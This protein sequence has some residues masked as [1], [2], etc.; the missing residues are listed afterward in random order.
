VQPFFLS[1]CGNY[2][3]SILA[4]FPHRTDLDGGVLRRLTLLLN[5]VDWHELGFVCDGRFLFS[6]RSLENTLLPEDFAAYEVG[7]LV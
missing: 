5:E 3:G 7:G 2:D 4:L 1:D 6:Q